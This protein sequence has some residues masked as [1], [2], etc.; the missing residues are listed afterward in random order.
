VCS[1]DLFVFEQEVEDSLLV[2]LAKITLRSWI[3]STT[4]GKWLPSFLVLIY[5][6][7]SS[8]R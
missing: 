5:Q 8:L 4:V 6:L 2:I 3:L 1:A 7:T